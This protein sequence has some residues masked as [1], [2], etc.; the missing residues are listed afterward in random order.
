M[1]STAE[2][3]VTK[4]FWSVTMFSRE[5]KCD[6]IL[7]RELFINWEDIDSETESSHGRESASFLIS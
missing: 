2:G 5:E 1:N 3:M 7:S 4:T 6:A